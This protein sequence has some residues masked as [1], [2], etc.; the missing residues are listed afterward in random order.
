MWFH[1]RWK[2]PI[3]EY[4]FANCWPWK[5]IWGS[6]LSTYWKRWTLWV[7]SL[8]CDDKV[9]WCIIKSDILVKLAGQVKVMT[10][11]IEVWT[12][13][14]THD[15]VIKWKHFPLYWPFVLGIHRPLAQ[16]PVTWSFDVFFDLCLN[17][18]LRKQS[19]G[20]WFETLSHSLWRHCNDFTDDIFKGIFVLQ[21]I[22]IL[23]KL[24]LK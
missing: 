12:K 16:R 24:S 18:R 17:K 13:W 23:N 1:I 8:L 14:S 3:L 4:E 2:R 15:D 19:W 5:Y 10:Y 9:K 22:W 21:T 20:W 7:H 6:I 11:N